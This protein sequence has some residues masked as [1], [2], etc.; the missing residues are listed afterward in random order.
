M[1][2]TLS[3]GTHRRPSARGEAQDLASFRDVNG[4]AQVCVAALVLPFHWGQQSSP[5]TASA[6]GS[7]P[8]VRGP[9]CR[10]DF[11]SPSGR[12]AQLTRHV[13]HI[14]NVRDLCGLAPRSCLLFEHS[15]TSFL[16]H[17]RFAFLLFPAAIDTNP[18]G[19]AVPVARQDRHS[20]VGVFLDGHAERWL[21]RRSRRGWGTVR[22]LRTR[23]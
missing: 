10:V 14:G 17:V 20:F 6:F 5:V 23:A 7:S 15:S 4:A 3:I 8:V 13:P 9:S 2:C 1:A 11:L 22:V 21:L 19:G 18:T 12:M 16:R